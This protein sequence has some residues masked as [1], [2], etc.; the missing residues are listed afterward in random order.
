[1]TRQGLSWNG[2]RAA[3]PAAVLLI[4]VAVALAA[5]DKTVFLEH[6]SKTT[7]SGTPDLRPDP[8][9]VGSRTERTGSGASKRWM[10]KDRGAR[11]ARKSV[12]SRSGTLGKYGRIHTVRLSKGKPVP[13]A[14]DKPQ[15]QEQEPTEDPTIQAPDTLEM[16]P[17]RGWTIMHDGRFDP[18]TESAFDILQ[19]ERVL[20]IGQ[21]EDPQSYQSGVIDI[22]ATLARLANRYPDGIQ[23]YVELDWEEP[24]FEVLH[25]GPTHP[26]YAKTLENVTE[27]VRRFKAVFPGTL[28]TQY[29]LPAIPYWVK[30]RDGTVVSWIDASDARRSEIFQELEAMRPLLDEMDWFAPRHYDFVPTEQI[31]EDRRAAQVAAECEHRAAIVRWLRKYVD[32]SDRPNRK[33]LPVTRTNWVGGATNYSEWV[34]MEI[35]VREYIDEQVMP[36]LLN[37]A[38]GIKLWQGWEIWMLHLAF[39]PPDS[40]STELRSKSLTHLRLLGIIAE[41]EVPDW[42]SAAQKRAIQKALGLRQMPYLAA[43]A[44]A[45]RSGIVPPIARPTSEAAG[46][47]AAESEPTGDGRKKDAPG[48]LRVVPSNSSR[49]RI[50]LRDVSDASNAR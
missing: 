28:V 37:G 5:E 7:A 20:G 4:A 8:A 23:G 6:A 17:L 22:Q 24:F 49:M 45:M 11:Q 32:D 40:I 35:P 1:M 25:H 34:E 48:R 39:I 19:T 43:M 47:E 2:Y 13:D 9:P 38:D 3:V 16:L 15:E 36:A 44:T 46:P 12:S 29:N 26:K 31:P 30:N 27:F 21:S 42:R 33:I 50:T 41:D 14:S 18:E 10:L